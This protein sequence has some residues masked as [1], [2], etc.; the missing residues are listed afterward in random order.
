MEPDVCVCSGAAK[1]LR[2]EAYAAWTTASRSPA[3]G[4]GDAPEL[5]PDL[6]PSE[7]QKEGPGRPFRDISALLRPGERGH[8]ASGPRVPMALMHHSGVRYGEALEVSE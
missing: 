7:L 6:F 1:A 5:Q 2:G 8:R 4:A 3:R